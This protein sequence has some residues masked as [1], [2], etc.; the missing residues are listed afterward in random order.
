MIL[1]NKIVIV[2]G[3][4]GSIGRAVCLKFASEGAIV[5]AVA[6]D[7]ENLNKLSNDIRSLGGQC[8][9]YY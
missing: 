2:Y 3:A 5:I 1:E 6:R 7:I 9:V 8:Y 4:T